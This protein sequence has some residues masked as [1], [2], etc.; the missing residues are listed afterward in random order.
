[1][2][3]RRRSFQ[4]HTATTRRERERGDSPREKKTPRRKKRRPNT[5][6]T[7]LKPTGKESHSPRRRLHAAITTRKTRRE[8]DTMRS[9]VRRTRKHTPRS[10]KRKRPNKRQKGKVRNGG[11]EIEVGETEKATTNVV[12]R[13]ARERKERNQTKKANANRHTNQKRETHTNS[14][15]ASSVEKILKDTRVN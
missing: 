2:P 4:K 11:I 3:S 10:T 6:K 7:G 12:E 1:M 13:K 15:N 8:S 9:H 5:T 14:Q